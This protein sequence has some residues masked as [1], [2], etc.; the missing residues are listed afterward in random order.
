MYQNNR[1]V[2]GQHSE[3]K[4][5]PYTSANG[6]RRLASEQN[7]TRFGNT[8]KVVTF[9]ILRYAILKY[10]SSCSSLALHYS[11][12]RFAV[13][14]EQ[15]YSYCFIAHSAMQYS[16]LVFEIV[17][18]KPCNIMD[19]A[20]KGWVGGRGQEGRGVEWASQR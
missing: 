3:I 2:L 19:G 8:N 17:F 9:C 13:L 16:L 6:S 11:H 5:D 15:A 4:L 14:V 10:L 20:Y 1:S 12:T 7:V 18:Y